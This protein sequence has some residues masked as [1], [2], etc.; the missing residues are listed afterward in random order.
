MTAR[1]LP[2][3]SPRLPKKVNFPEMK[4]RAEEDDIVGSVVYILHR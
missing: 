1:P 3:I 4:M 2:N